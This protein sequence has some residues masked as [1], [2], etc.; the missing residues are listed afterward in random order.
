MNFAIGISGM[1]AAQRAMELVGTNLSNAA[2][3][4]YHRQRISLAALELGVSSKAAI[5]GVEVL[6]SSRS[7]DVLLEREQM[8]MKPELGEVEQELQAL[9]SVEAVFATIEGDPL[10]DS[11]NEFF[12]AIHDLAADP[13]QLAYAQDVVWTADAVATNFRQL[14]D[15]LVTLKEQLL[16][17]GK[18]LAEELNNHAESAATLNREIELAYRRGVSPNLLQDQRDLAI[19]K[20]SEL[21][22]VV[23]NG[24]SSG[25]GQVDA[26]AWGTPVVL[27]ESFQSLEVGLTADGKMGVGVKGADSLSSYASGGK[28]GALVKLYN[29]VIPEYEDRLNTLAREVMF[30]FNRQHCQGI[31]PEGSFSNLAGEPIDKAEELG[32]LDP[33]IN[34][35]TIHMRV[36][37]P[38]GNVQIRQIDV[39]QYQ[40][41][42]YV[43]SQIN[44]ASPGNIKADI[45]GGRITID[46]YHGY[47]FDFVPDY[48][49][50]SEARNVM[51]LGQSVA[52]INDNYFTGNA[53]GDSL[54][55]HLGLTAGEDITLAIGNGSK[56]LYEVVD[57][58]NDLSNTAHAGWNCASAVFDETA[59]T[60]SLQLENYDGAASNVTNIGAVE[61]SAS[62]VPVAL[63]DFSASAAWAGIDPTFKV[64]GYYTGPNQTYTFQV[65]GAG[66]EIGIDEEV[67]LDV[68]N[69]DGDYVKTLK[70]GQGYPA[71]DRLEVEEGMYVSFSQGT[72][73][74]GE[75]FTVT[76]RSV[77]D[78][79]DFLMG[80]GLNTFFR[81]TSAVDIEVREPYYDLPTLLATSL[82]PAGQD[83]INVQKLA[84][85]QREELKNLKG[86]TF[87]EYFNELV[88]TIGQQVVL[89]EARHESLSNVMRELD[90]QKDVISGVDPN[91]EAANLLMFEKLFQ[92]M[93]KFINTQNECMQYLMDVL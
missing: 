25:D 66:G 70:V 90:N 65:N 39:D 6:G 93:S 30:Q 60:Y 43:V 3:E 49:D 56:T 59:G 27:G 45:A 12:S 31:G 64:D 82:T 77:S 50:T 15:F 46:T 44:A 2:T 37:D 23:V 24:I 81:G 48:S 92:S 14:S 54:T 58:L 42:E 68:F 73:N 11:L 32:N 79:S 4:G 47:Q 78:D 57:E 75:S 72:L 8:R 16:T 29:E 22:E 35:G 10:G 86:G 41:A 61:W 53:G 21:A 33:P 91:E 74:A 67:L 63:A 62:A 76:A 19:G 87:T 13:T 88:T 69:G 20:I 52:D 28:I 40:T 5:G 7:Y 55:F 36:I 18:H 85:L 34:D 17:Q 51:L 9:V 71:G 80:T 38:D 1:M 84:D 26:N 89:R 83:N